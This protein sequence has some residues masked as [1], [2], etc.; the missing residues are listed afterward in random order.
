MRMGRRYLW[1]LCL[2]AAPAAVRQLYMAFDVA[3][4]SMVQEVL[5]ISSV[6]DV[7]RV[8]RRYLSHALVPLLVATLLIGARVRPLRYLPLVFLVGFMLPLLS[9]ALLDR[10]SVV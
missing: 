2:F 9:L 1:P 3:V 4:W 5:H 8:G 10:K 7:P 6:K